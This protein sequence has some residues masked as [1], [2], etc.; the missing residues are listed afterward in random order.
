MQ[1]AP[2]LAS[3]TMAFSLC[4]GCADLTLVDEEDEAEAR[5]GV[6]G[7]YAACPP[8]APRCAMSAFIHE[9]KPHP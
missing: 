7:V 3:L 8:I 9:R 1:C 6:R 5:L 4:P 2:S